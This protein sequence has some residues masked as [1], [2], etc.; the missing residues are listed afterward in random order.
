MVGRPLV[1]ALV[2]R[3][4]DVVALVRDEARARGALGDA[5]VAD[6]LLLPRVPALAADR[7]PGEVHHRV[8]A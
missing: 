1:R 6:E 3:G 2:A 5:A 8:R 7:L 4:D